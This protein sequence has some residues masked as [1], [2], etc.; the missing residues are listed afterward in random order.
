MDHVLPVLRMV[1]INNVNL[2]FWMDR[3]D[4]S[5]HKYIYLP[6]IIVL[7]SISVRS[8]P[9]AP[10]APNIIAFIWFPLFIVSAVLLSHRPLLSV[11][12]PSPSI[13]ESSCRH[14]IY[15][16][17]VNAQPHSNHY[18]HTLPA[19]ADDTRRPHRRVSDGDASTC[20]RCQL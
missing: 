2:Q 4:F 13:S 18:P 14:G 20:W 1:K 6:E 19:I 5:T 15:V 16:T 7:S 3:I 17:V 9:T 11:A 12:Q 10:V 8:L